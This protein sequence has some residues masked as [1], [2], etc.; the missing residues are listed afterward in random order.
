MLPK[1]QNLQT[2]IKV[3]LTY[4]A[5]KFTSIT[6]IPILHLFCW[7]RRLEILRPVTKY[8][9]TISMQYSNNPILNIK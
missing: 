5:E 9:P 7:L 6:N 1:Q 4:G 2:Q 3:N 8:S